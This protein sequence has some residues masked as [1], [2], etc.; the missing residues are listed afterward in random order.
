MAVRAI[1]LPH[2]DSDLVCGVLSRHE[3]GMAIARGA[4]HVHCSPLL[5]ADPCFVITKKILKECKPDR[6][7]WEA[8]TTHTINL[9]KSANKHAIIQKVV[10]ETG[11]GSKRDLRERVEMVT[12]ELLTNALYHAYRNF[13]GS[14]KY[15]RRD[16]VIL[17]PREQVRFQFAS[18]QS[19]IYLSVSDRGGSLC[20]SD[21]SGS[22]QR[23]YV[24]KENQIEKK[25]SGAGLGLYMVFEM[26]THLK[27]TVS[28]DR[29]SRICCWLSDNRTFDPGTFSFN[30]FEKEVKE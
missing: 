25:E 30:F 14:P 23:C 9:V 28:P 17:S 8:Q 12:E 24:N 2:P 18:Y 20:F 13:D 19:G 7:P 4:R 26:V 10:S 1:N 5:E 3:A 15:R 22:F 21:I 6:Y 27:M 29:Q 16:S 11:V